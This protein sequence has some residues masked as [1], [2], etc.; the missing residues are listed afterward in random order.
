MF[1]IANIYDNF[2][3]LRQGLCQ[4]VSRIVTFVY[5]R[6]YLLVLAGLNLLFWLIAYLINVNV[7]QDLI[8]LHYNVIFGV[9]LI[10]NVKRIFIIP[11]LS[12]VIILINVMLLLGLYRHKDF[13]FI[14]HILLAGSV[15]INVFLF[16]A[17]I[18]VYL[19]NFYG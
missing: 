6:L 10:G 13:K 5:I 3:E 1:T 9:D 8:I 16:I 14:S 17:L 12:L 11:V 19:I 18:S 15:A 2:Y 4:A 7:S